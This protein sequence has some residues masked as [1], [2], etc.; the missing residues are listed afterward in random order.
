MKKFLATFLAL[1]LAGGTMAWA[2]ESD[3]TQEAPVV[4][5]ESSSL[6]ELLQLVEEGR[7]AETAWH[8]QRE[9]EFT[10][11]RDRQQQLLREARQTKANE[12]ARSERLEAQFQRNETE[13]ANLQQRLADRLGNLQ[14]LFGVLQQVAGDARGVFAGSLMTIEYPDRDQRIADLI[15]KSARGTELPTIAEIEGLW[16]ELQREMTESGK[17]KSLPYQV[18]SVDGQ[19]ENVNLIRVGDFNLVANGKYYVFN[20]TTSRVEELVRQPSGRF[21]STISDLESAN[22]GEVVSFG[23]D[24][25]RGQLLKVLIQAPSWGERFHQGGFVGYIIAAMGVIGILF[26][27][28]RVLYLSRVSAK[29]R[30]QT[31]TSQASDS[32]PLGRVLTVY[33]NNKN[34]DVETLELKLDEAIL[35]ETPALERFLTI[36]KIISAVAPLFG[37]LGTVTGMIETFQAITLFGTGDPKLMAGGISQALVTTV[38]GLVVAIPTLFLHSMVAGMSKKVIHVLEE[39]SAG[40]I[41]THAE[42]EAK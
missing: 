24:P 3:A 13:I 17:V 2:Q 10:A 37:L 5:V 22:S 9:A 35:K 26:V 42:K 23:I 36:I 15:E 6:D 40:I 4:E 1:T 41:A 18:A 31:K 7:V 34:V 28:E 19:A 39:Q 8:R 12:E 30:A 33:E 21:T 11:N 38:L 16:F 32:N 27:L 25:S 20:P 29:V 14:E